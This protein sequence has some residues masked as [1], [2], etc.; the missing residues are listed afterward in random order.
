MGWSVGKHHL[1]VDSRGPFVLVS[2]DEVPLKGVVIP[3]RVLGDYPIKIGKRDVVLRRF[4]NLDVAR[5]ELWIDGIRVPPSE[6]MIPRRTP[7]K[8]AVCTLHPLPQSAYREQGVVLAAKIAC[9]V[10]RAPICKECI[11]VDDVRCKPCFEKATV[12]MHKADR[13]LRIKGVVAG[14][15]VAVLLMI[16]GLALDAK[17]MFVAG[18]GALVLVVM[19]AVNGLWQEKREAALRRPPP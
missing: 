15:S 7:P 10:C 18:A 13:A 17:P 9:G 16:F 2:V 1:L 14:L 8:D 6:V 3:S 5:T 11:A 19:L 4:R 12:E